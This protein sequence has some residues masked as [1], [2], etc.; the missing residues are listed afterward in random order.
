MSNR[1]MRLPLMLSPHRIRQLWYAPLLALAMGLMMLRVLIMARLLDVPAFAEFSG[2]ILVS[3]TFCM[4]GCLGLQSM[5]QREWPV[6]LVRH[7]E[8]RGLVRA[9]Q[10]NLVALGCGLAGLLVAAFGIS[11]TGTTPALLGV[12][13][14]HGLSQQVFLVAT[15]ESRS[16]GDALRFAHQNLVR[17]VTALALS[18]AVALWTG[19]AELVLAIDALVTIALSQRLF[20]NSLARTRFGATAVYRLAMRRLRLVRWRSAL[21]MM[22]IMA[23]GFALLNA[24]RWLA[25]ERLD[26]GGFASYSFAWVVLSIAQSAQAVINASLYP[27]LARRFAEYGR[28]VAFGVCLRVSASILAAG[29]VMVVPLYL[30]LD[31]GIHRWYPG[32]SDARALIP[33]F[34]ATAVLRV[35]DFWTGFLL[36]V[37]LERGLLR[38]NLCA[39]VFGVLVWVALVRPWSGEPVTL[40]QV[41]WLAALLTLSAYLT[42]AG[43]AWRARHG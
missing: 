22:L 25:S 21:T 20:L 2:G 36:I 23:I 35:S 40:Q 10:C 6:N 28:R 32:Y 17:A 19:S 42:A 24:D 7:Q 11:L 13:L 31:Y 3:S 26:P 12:G 27:L 33:L 14:L 37:G 15:V 41:S 8:L 43:A 29:A 18:V 1:T 4:I 30:I 5:L 38:L 39:M 34:L 9:A 16:R